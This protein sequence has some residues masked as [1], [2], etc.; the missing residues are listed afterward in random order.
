LC[1]SKDNLEEKD[2]LNLI[3]KTNFDILMSIVNTK[4]DTQN[5]ANVAA[6]ELVLSLIFP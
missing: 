6:M 5:K 1:F 4:T 2:K 3:N